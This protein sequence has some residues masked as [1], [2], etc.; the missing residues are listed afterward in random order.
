MVIVR[1][2]D[3]YRNDVTLFMEHRDT[4]ANSNKKGRLSKETTFF[5]VYGGAE[6][7]RTPDGW[8]HNPEL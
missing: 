3:Y 6:G 4:A 5:I 7:T 2:A 8:N 1:L